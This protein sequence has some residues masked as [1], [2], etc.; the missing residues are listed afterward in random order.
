MRRIKKSLI[1]I[2]MVVMMLGFSAPGVVYA[3]EYDIVFD[4]DED[5]EDEDEGADLGDN[6]WEDDG[7][8]DD[9]GDDLG[10]NYWV[11]DGSE[12][13]SGDGDATDPN[14]WE[15]DGSEPDYEEPEEEEEEDKEEPEEI[16][17]EYEMEDYIFLA[18]R[19]APFIL[20]DDPE[21]KASQPQTQ[22]YTWVYVIV[23]ILVLAAAG[24]VAFYFLKVKPGIVEDKPN[25]VKNETVK[26]ETPK[27]DNVEKNVK[28]DN[29][30][31]ESSNK[32]S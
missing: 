17:Y 8:G 5:L 16:D 21:D 13:D 11:D 18:E 30:P 12:D 26:A 28:T 20:A 25:A 22:D 32:E 24:G 3:V 14:F 2:L 23:G 29:N 6:Y 15:D 1:Y 9:G 7:S 19:L 31:D 27:V 4:E 10:P